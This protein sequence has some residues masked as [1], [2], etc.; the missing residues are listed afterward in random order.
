MKFLLFLLT[1]LAFSAFSQDVDFALNLVKNNDY[2]LY[3][4]SNIDLFEKKNGKVSKSKVN[5]K[6]TVNFHVTKVDSKEILCDMRYEYFQMEIIT[7]DMTLSITTDKVYSSEDYSLEGIM[8]RIF[9]EMPKHVIKMKLDHQGKILSSQGFDELFT[10]AIDD[11][12]KLPEDKREQLKRDMKIKY[13]Q[14]NFASNFE[15]LTRVYPQTKI[16]LNGV[17]NKTHLINSEKVNFNA[18]NT[19]KLKEVTNDF[20][21][22][23]DQI[24]YEPVD[25]AEK[26]SSKKEGEGEGMA[27]YKFNKK[28]GW[29]YESKVIQRIKLYDDKVNEPE[30]Y[31]FL[32][33]ETNYTDH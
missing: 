31:M 16:Q 24:T 32:L 30:N 6:A 14:E 12:K 17:W 28:S 3:I 27:Y 10:N 19:F 4:Q 23:E 33:T 11:F 18:V 9:A 5:M 29:I 7:K 22:V 2:K 26:N 25:A 8:G 1:T 15:L 21:L 13:G 20:L